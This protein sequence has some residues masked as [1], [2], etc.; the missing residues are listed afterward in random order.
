MI[1]K[2]LFTA[3]RKIKGP[4]LVAFSNFDDTFYVQVSKKDLMAQLSAR[5]NQNDETGLILDDNG[6]LD[7]DYESQL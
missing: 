1:A 4:V 2:N 7:K 5:F 6:Y 3:V